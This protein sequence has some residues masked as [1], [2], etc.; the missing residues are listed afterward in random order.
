MMQRYCYK[1]LPLPS[2]VQLPA[3]CVV[4][5]GLVLLLFPSGRVLAQEVTVSGT[6]T[7]AET[8]ETLVG[9]N[10]RVVGTQIGTATDAQGQ[11]ELSVPDP[12]TDSLEFTFVGYEPRTVAVEG[13]STI[14]VTMQSLTLSGGEV[15]VTGYSS[16]QRQD[17]TGSVDVVNTADMQEIASTQV[18]DQLQG[19]A[20]GVTIIGSGEPGR[21]PDI[22][23]RGINTFGNNKPLFVV[24]GVPTQNI[25]DLNSQDVSSIQVLKS[26]SAASM[27][28]ARASNGV[29]II[30]TKKGEGDLSVQFSSYAGIAQ[31]PDNRPYDISGPQTRADHEWLAFRNSGIA[32]TDPQYG[33]GEEPRLPDF[34]LPSG[35][36]E[37]DPG[38]DPD[39]YFVNPEYTDP[40]QLQEFQQIVRA[41][42]QG[43]NWFDEI[44]ETA[45][46]MKTDLTVSGGGEQGSFLFS[47]GYLNHEGTLRET[48]NR[49]YNVR[50]N[51]SF[52]VTDNIRIGENLSFSVSENKQQG[53]N[54]RKTA[55]DGVTKMRQIIPVRD[56][57]G[58]WAGTAGGGLGNFNN[59][60][61]IRERAR[62]EIPLDKR[63]FGNAFVEATFLND[64]TVKTLF[65]GSF[66]SG[67]W[68]RFQ[69][70]TFAEAENITTNQW[71][72]RAWNNF[73]WTFSNTLNYQ[74]TFAQNH[75]V[76]FLAGVEWQQEETNFEEASVTD[77]FSF[78]LDFVNLDNG[79]GD[80]NISSTF[81]ESTLV[82]Q[83]GKLDYN[84]DGRYFVS[85][86]LRRDGSSKFLNDR[87]GLF[88]AGSVAWRISEESFL[89]DL[90]WLSSLK[91]RAGWGV[92]GNQLNV[93]P[94]NAYSLF[95]RTNE[96]TSYDVQGTNTDG[97]QGFFRSEIG[98]P[99]TKW[100]RDENLNFGVD[101][102]ILSGQLEITAD[103]YRKDIEDLLF[104]PE[105]PAT[106]GQADPPFVNVASMENTGF[107]A[108]LRGQF[109]VG[110]VQ[111]DGNLNL[112][113][114]NNE[115]TRV[116]GAQ[117]FFS[118]AGGIRNEVGQPMSSFFG[119]QVAGFWESEEEVQ[120]ANDQAP[121]GQF[122]VG[123]A[124]GRFRYEDVNGDGQITTDDRTFLGNPHPNFTTGLNLNLQ[125][126]NWDLNMSLYASQGVELWNAVKAEHDFFSANPLTAKSEE[127]FENSWKPG[128]DNSDATVP[129]QEIESSFSTHEAPNSYFV[130]G[131]SYLRV[132]NLGVGYTMPSQWVPGG[133]V[134]VY[135]KTSNLF[136]LTEYS[137]PD[138]EVGGTSPGNVTSIG[139][140]SV[141]YPRPRK[142][143]AGFNLT[144]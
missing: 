54:R 41:N 21:E 81:R 38:T 33:D 103:Y 63:V 90:G 8:D 106:A 24:D 50:A 121:D 3:V 111:F 74:N 6:V 123:A 77:F 85:G 10:V 56:I 40:A 60:V 44:Y 129:I 28:G 80:K 98:A 27:Y 4:A 68:K 35:A 120:Q 83:F 105:L 42:K 29:V 20:S 9:A 2:A 15:V 62:A 130:E 51:T 138:P 84:Y 78:D 48:F 26:A 110:E 71:T 113:T 122:Q 82:S 65:G 125:Y 128:E 46:L 57:K 116:A 72:E 67:F 19:M 93:D 143:I 112:T 16:Q 12:A 141:R 91:F 117:D 47:A 55:F 144:F 104:D 99:T 70:P 58:N 5:L 23:I 134:R 94:N 75:E 53:G 64:F 101:L 7:D 39:D 18:T 36:M 25:Q 135:V 69:F 118:G 22:R 31:Q 86:T 13:R 107:D 66:E 132:R 100:E 87:Y 52:N 136:T 89:P 14:D 73:D 88:P 92:M 137:N 108:S 95:A 114:Y 96:V 119:Y 49:R 76:T 115:I 139:F 140:D 30:E 1:N 32:P 126:E 45:P 59:P 97:E 17:L 133:D 127:A 43:T 102:A 34:I 37:G 142:F 11:Y 61:A 124:P 109:S 131:A 79:A